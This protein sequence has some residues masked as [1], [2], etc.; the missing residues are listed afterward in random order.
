M[1]YFPH[2]FQIL[3][4]LPVKSI[5]HRH[6]LFLIKF[7]ILRSSELL[8]TFDFFVLTLEACKYDP[9]KVADIHVLLLLRNS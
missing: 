8:K 6:N 5:S 7:R 1:Q 9:I 3:L 4:K 2:A